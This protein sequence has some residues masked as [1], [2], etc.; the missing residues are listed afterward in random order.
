MHKPQGK[1]EEGKTSG[2]SEEKKGI[3]AQSVKPPTPSQATDACTGDEKHNGKQKKENRK[4][5]SGSSTQ[6][7]RTISSRHTTRM[8]HTVGLF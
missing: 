6:L 8:D 1:R 2:K 5:Q 4:K 3:E 7:L